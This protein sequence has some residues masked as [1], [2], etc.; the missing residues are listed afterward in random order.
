MNQSIVRLFAVV[1]LMFTLLVVWTTRWT[2]LSATALQ[3]D[4]LNRLEFF[5]SLK[6]K[7]GRILAD[8][9]TVLARSVPVRG[10]TWT[11]NYP[12]GSLFAQPIGYAIAQLGSAAGLEKY[13]SA[14]LKGKSTSALSSVFGPLGGN[15][16]IGNDVYT[17]LDPRAQRL[18]RTLLAGRAGSVV[19]LDPRTGA[20]RVLYANPGYDDN[21]PQSAAA[22]ATQYDRA[23]QAQYPPGSTFKVI[24]AAAALDSGQYT[25]NSLIDGKS[26]LLVSGVPLQ[27]DNNDQFGLVTLTVALTKSINTVFA[28]VGQKVGLS[29]MA[30]YMKRFGFYGPP[31]LDLPAGEMAGSGERGPSGRLLS[32]TSGLID[33][34]RMSIGQDKLTVTPLQMAMVVAA[35]A[36]G[37][38]LMRPRLTTRVVNPD[39][40]TVESFPPSVFNQVMKP[41]TAAELTQMMT[42]VVEEGTGTAA[43]LLGLKVAGKTGTAQVGGTGSNLDDPW[44]IGFGPVGN[45]KVAVAVTLEKIP[46]GYGGTYAAPIAAQIIKQL[47]AAGP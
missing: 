14:A 36:N 33:L 22:G 47:V 44:F 43:N 19:A 37:G 34:G 29:T 26:P 45:P 21:N 35:V 13:R 7:R 18:A 12:T 10:G 31:P 15:P 42:S 46:L 32:P 23:V 40:Q 30:M 38:K 39:G 3:S 27:N 2:V 8:D 28:Q 25:P 41:T 4:P 24:T 5:A 20:V 16:R 1:I 11:R 17:T 9:G 6:V